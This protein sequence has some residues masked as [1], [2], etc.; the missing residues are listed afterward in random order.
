MRNFLPNAQ[1]SDLVL[2]YQGAFYEGSDGPERR[3]G[4]WRKL[5]ER[6]TAELSK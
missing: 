3:E 6:L 5:L 4:G 2:T 1:G